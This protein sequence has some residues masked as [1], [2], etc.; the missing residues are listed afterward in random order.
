[1]KKKFFVSLSLALVF[2]VLGSTGLLLWL[3]Q[4]SHAIEM[5]HSIFGLS[6][7]SVAVFHIANNW[8]SLRSYA[9][10][11]KQ[12]GL[13][14]ELVWA[15]VLTGFLLIGSVSEVLEPIAEFGRRFA[16]K[17]EEKS[18]SL[19]FEIK[20]SASISGPSTEIWLQIK[21]EFKGAHLGILLLDAQGKTLDTLLALPAEPKG[22]GSHV[23]LS[24]SLKCDVPQT[25]K[26]GIMRME[27]TNWEEIP[28]P[29]LGSGMHKIALASGSS[30]QKVLVDVP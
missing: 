8:T 29:A 9:S 17:R 15:L 13:P 30:L 18:S 22:P 4:K 16:P 21:P 20:S 3:K 2:F 5:A 12:G 23:I 6:F 24:C 10:N 28:L 25:L 7:L 19:Q 11:K 26:V 27:G 1:M 14:K